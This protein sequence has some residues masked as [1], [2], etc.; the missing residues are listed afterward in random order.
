MKS[1]LKAIDLVEFR[2]LEQ[3]AT[4]IEKPTLQRRGSSTTGV[5]QKDGEELE[6]VLNYIK[7][8]VFDASQRC[9]YLQIQGDGYMKLYETG[10]HKEEIKIPLAK[11]V[12]VHE[13]YILFITLDNESHS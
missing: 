3:G 5:D 8:P 2:L 9:N 4:H 12:G 10:K 7:Q 1:I 6:N 11:K 13:S